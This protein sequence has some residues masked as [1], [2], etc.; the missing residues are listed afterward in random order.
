VLLNL[1][2]NA[3]D[4]MPAGGRIVVTTSRAGREARLDVSDSG[5]GI[6]AELHEKVF[7]PFFSTKGGSGSGLG[8]SVVHGI[9]ASHG[10]RIQ[11][12]S[13]PGKGC[14]FSVYLPLSQSSPELERAS[15][16]AD[17]GMPRGNSEH[18]LLV[19]D[20]DSVRGGMVQSLEALGYRVTAVESAEAVEE[21]PPASTFDLLLTDLMLPGAHGAELAARLRN[22]QP[23]LVVIIMSGYAPDEGL[24]QEVGGGGVQ[25]LQKPFD[26]GTLA[27]TV[28]AGL[29][30]RGE[31]QGGR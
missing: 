31:G 20:E 16:E 29:S 23:G 25:Y 9:V 1:V 30:L 18:I 7:E 6:P 19:E 4:A 13:S 26:L 8:L 15:L 12:H 27:R 17:T 24:R 21:L 14:T 28:R 10:G 11:L 2:V 22:R 3:V 5:E